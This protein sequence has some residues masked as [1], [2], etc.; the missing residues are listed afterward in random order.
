MKLKKKCKSQCILKKKY[1]SILWLICE[2]SL[3]NIIFG[4]IEGFSISITKPTLTTFGRSRFIPW[5]SYKKI[6]IC[7]GHRLEYVKKVNALT[8][9]TTAATRGFNETIT[10]CGACGTVDLL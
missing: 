2:T 10:H 8:R 1:S 9:S 7:L 6:S 4:V 3:F 5:D